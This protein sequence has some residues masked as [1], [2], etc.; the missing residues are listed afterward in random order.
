M[1]STFYAKA[2]AK[3]SYSDHLDSYIASKLEETQEI[4]SINYK[5][6]KSQPL[7]V[8]KTFDS[9]EIVRFKTFFNYNFFFF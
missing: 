8:Y 5:L 1:K 6:F 3:L 4:R 2:V 9:K 7:Y